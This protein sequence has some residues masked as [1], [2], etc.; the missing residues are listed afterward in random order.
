MSK[1]LPNLDVYSD[2]LGSIVTYRSLGLVKDNSN[3][4]TW[5]WMGLVKM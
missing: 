2:N 3:S 5:G 4:K 1:R